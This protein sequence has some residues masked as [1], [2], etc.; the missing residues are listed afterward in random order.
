MTNMPF[1]DQISNLNNEGRDELVKGN[2]NGA[3]NSFRCALKHLKVEILHHANRLEK[4]EDI[5]CLTPL[6][7][8]NVKKS[9]IV[10]GDHRGGTDGAGVVM[11]KEENDYHQYFIFSHA[12][13]LIM[14]HRFSTDE[15][16]N[17]KVYIAIVVFN[18]ALT[19]H[20]GSLKSENRRSLTK[21]Q[22]LYE[23]CFDLLAP[24]IKVYCCNGRATNN[25]VFDLLVM[26]LL[27]NL[28]L[29]YFEIVDPVQSCATFQLLAKYAT[30]VS[31]F[32]PSRHKARNGSRLVVSQPAGTTASSSRRDPTR[33]SEWRANNDGSGAANEE[34]NGGG[35]IDNNN[36]HSFVF[37]EVDRMLLN[38]NL[39]KIAMASTPV[40]PAA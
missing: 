11:L 1:L 28:A 38:A 22:S 16:E 18:L 2:L 10:H 39:V 23:K 29:V 13:P 15:R 33:T 12:I 25:T 37:G 14:G 19:L 26:A 5:A 9:I 35:R 20:L 3:M 24:I 6:H 21:A 27:N 32:R 40:A 31:F 4:E 30:I 17:T 36:D 34:H 8:Q 7:L